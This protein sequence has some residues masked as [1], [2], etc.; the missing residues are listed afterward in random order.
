MAAEGYNF[1]ESETAVLLVNLGTPRALSFF[2]VAKFL[3]SFLWDPRVVELPRWIWWGILHGLVLPIRTGSSLKSYRKI[4]RPEGSPLHILTRRLTES[5]HAFLR[6]TLGKDLP[7]FYGM[8]YG[9]PNLNAALERIEKI[10]ASR[11]IVI[12]LF[13]QY[14]ATTTAAVFDKLVD[15]FKHQRFIPSLIFVNGYS[16]SMSYQVALADSI[17]EYWRTHGRSERLLFSFHG[18]PAQYEKAGDPYPD[19]CR[20]TAYQIAA[21]LG[22]A[23]HAWA[24]SFQSRFGWKEWVKP[25]TDQQLLQWAANGV[26]SVDVVSPS[27]SVDCLETLEELNIQNRQLFLSHGGHS[28]H[29]IPA[30][31]DSKGHQTFLA[32]L[33]QKFI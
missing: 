30:L 16:E 33:I 3:R 6:E 1:H 17:E 10:K 11:L 14:S 20:R 18:L 21:R 8:T 5:L 22:I 12:P 29:Y 25:Y 23:E 13:P 31:N 28:F 32:E 15:Y 2:E 26:K 7:V 19:Y 27:F 4:W 24:I 9:S